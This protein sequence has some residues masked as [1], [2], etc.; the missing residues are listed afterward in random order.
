M[1]RP[2]FLLVCV[3]V[4]FAKSFMSMEFSIQFSSL[5]ALCPYQNW[6]CMEVSQLGQR[7]SPVCV[8][9]CCHEV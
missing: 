7:N 1:E 3:D 4:S 8:V 5:V 2:C 9:F 6:C